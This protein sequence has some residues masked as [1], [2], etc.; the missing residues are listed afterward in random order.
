MAGARSVGHEAVMHCLLPGRAS[1]SLLLLRESSQGL[2]RFRL[3]F[4]T[5]TQHTPFHN[6]LPESDLLK[7]CAKI[8]DS[9][10]LRCLCLP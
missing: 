10:S 9:T 1:F 5:C 3:V 7:L 2:G 6:P 8:S 4:H